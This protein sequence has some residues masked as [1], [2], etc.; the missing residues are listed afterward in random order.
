ME[1]EVACLDIT[2]LS[3]GKAHLIAVGLWTDV[4]A[5]ILRAPSL[6]VVTKEPMKGG[7][8]RSSTSQT[9]RITSNGIET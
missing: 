2:P 6:E 5:V 3:E 9:V 4:S 8:S 1:N 7:M